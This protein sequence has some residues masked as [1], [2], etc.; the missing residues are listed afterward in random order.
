VGPEEQLQREAAGRRAAIAG[1]VG[2]LVLQLPGVVLRDRVSRLSPS[3]DSPGGL[4]ELP[5]FYHEHAVEIFAGG[6]LL[7]LGYLALILPLDYLF[8]AT[9]NRQPEVPGAARVMTYAGPA[10]LAIGG[11]VNE[12]M[13][14]I[15][16][17]DYLAHEQGNYF[18]AR[19]LVQG[20]SRLVAAVAQLAGTLALAFAF[21]LISL[22][23]MRVG[24]LTRFMGVLG[25]IVGVVLVL[26]LGGPVLQWFWLGALAYLF[27]GRWPG[28]VPP[29]W[30]TGRAEPWPSARELREQRERERAAAEDAEPRSE[31]VP[32]PERS[33]P[34]SRKRRR[35]RRR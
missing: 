11:I 17:S 14:T 26:R 12:V 21:L 24:L 34:V 35:K 27:A 23:A 4:V 22:H 18:A 9:R 2:A 19:E 6:I 20:E 32:A 15:Q 28:G 10:L 16:V 31:T 33:H 30:R 7:A 25:I 13:L 8:K 1:A 3:A 29:A 5:R